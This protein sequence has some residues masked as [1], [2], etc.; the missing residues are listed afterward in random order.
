MVVSVKEK[1]QRDCIRCGYRSDAMRVQQV[2]SKRLAKF[3]LAL[4]PNKT[5]LVEFGRFADR[6]AQKR[7]QGSGY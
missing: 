1:V 6:H 3:G 7:G 5:K 2:L 4:E